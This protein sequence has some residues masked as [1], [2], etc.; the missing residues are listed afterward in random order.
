MAFV[1]RSEHAVSMTD[2]N[3][4]MFP[5]CTLADGCW[6]LKT[7]RTESLES[8]MAKAFKFYRTSDRVSIWH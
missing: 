4:D 5:A 8:Q 1:I 3:L 6:R 7:P 2:L